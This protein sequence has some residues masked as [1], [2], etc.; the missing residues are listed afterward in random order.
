M[1]AFTF[2][3]KRV[4]QSDSVKAPSALRLQAKLIKLHCEMQSEP[5]ENKHELKDKCR[6]VNLL[7]LCMHADCEDH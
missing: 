7:L 3:L 1:G 4:L 6:C 5:E 2:F